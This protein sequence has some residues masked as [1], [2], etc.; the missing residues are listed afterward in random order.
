V[1]ARKTSAP[2]GLIVF[3]WYEKNFRVYLVNRSRSD[4][5]PQPRG[6]K[7]PLLSVMAAMFGYLTLNIKNGGP[8]TGGT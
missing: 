7:P 5:N 6:S 3:D 8:P 2:N 1:S 4:S